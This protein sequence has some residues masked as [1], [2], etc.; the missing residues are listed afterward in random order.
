MKRPIEIL[1]VGR[2]LRLL[3]KAV[4]PE[5]LHADLGVVY[6]PGAEG[7]RQAGD[8][9]RVLLGL[10]KQPGGQKPL[11]VGAGQVVLQQQ[12][13]QLQGLPH[14]PPLVAI[15]FPVRLLPLCLGLLEQASKVPL[16]RR[17]RP[18]RRR[19]WGLLVLKQIFKL[20]RLRLPS[21]LFRL[22]RL[23]IR[24]RWA[25]RL[26]RPALRFFRRARPGGRRRGFQRLPALALGLAGQPAGLLVSRVEPLEA[27]WVLLRVGLLQAVGIGLAH[28]LQ[29]GGAIQPQLPPG[30]AHG[31][32]SCS[33]LSKKGSGRAS[34]PR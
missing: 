5:Q 17:L 27:L 34:R 14:H 24:L 33:P 13:H 23:P 18:G 19:F 8:K 21:F 28:L 9:R 29:G 30:P 26:G 32:S 4:G 20:E 11:P 12:A 16:L 6:R 3:K 1:V 10:E 31:S 7:L 22:L 2:D 25:L 15:F